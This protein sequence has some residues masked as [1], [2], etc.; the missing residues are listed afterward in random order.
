M[1]P[2]LEMLHNPD[3]LA[4]L[5]STQLLDSPAEEAFDRLTRL[6]ARILD[7]PIALVSLVD[8]DRQFF[9]SCLGLA[10]PWASQRQTPL[11]YSFCQHVVATGQ[12]LIIDDARRHDLVRESPAVSEFGV[13][14]YAGIPLVLPDKHVLGSFCVLDQ[15]PRAWTDEQISL[16][17]DLAAG[18][19]TE[20]Q[21]R[22]VAAELA[23]GQQRR[24]VLLRVARRLASESEPGRVLRALLEEGVALFGMDNGVV[25]RWDPGDRTL[26][27][28]ES[29]LP[30]SETG[31]VLDLQ[32]SADGRAI[33][34]QRVVVIEDYQ[35]AVGQKTPA[36]RAGAQLVVA[37]PLQHEDRLLGTLS[38]SSRSPTARFI[39]DDSTILELL[40][41][42]AVAVLMG[43][44]AAR[45]AGVVLA[46]RTAQHE[47]NNSLTVASGLMQRLSGDPNL[48]PPLQEWARTATQHARTAAERLRQLQKLTEVAEVTWGSS[49]TTTIKLDG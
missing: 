15:Q 41:G 29:F 25:A 5:H 39:E 3:R 17:R 11:R 19:L 1:Q 31:T 34:E 9:K 12:A 32:D 8:G 48:A 40:A 13:L 46:A 35:R 42:L 22:A 4:A 44:D 10:E 45:L 6:A 36:G 43:Q 2:L 21:Q 23:R 28:A 49:G 7:A 30:S 33:R 20:I 27:C 18:V 37:V 24:E 26:T 47:I 16:L 14:A 38:F